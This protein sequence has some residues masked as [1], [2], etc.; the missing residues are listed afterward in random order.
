MLINTPMQLT[1]LVRRMQICVITALMSS[2]PPGSPFLSGRMTNLL[3]YSSLSSGLQIWRNL[4]M[5]PRSCRQ[6]Q[7]RVQI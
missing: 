4:T 7:I 6:D 1:S 3:K 2:A 5:E